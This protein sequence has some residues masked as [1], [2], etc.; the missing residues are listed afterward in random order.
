MGDRNA[1][2]RGQYAAESWGKLAI[3]AGFD[4]VNTESTARDAFRF[5]AKEIDRLKDAE[6]REWIGTMSRMELHEEFQKTQQAAA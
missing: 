4:P 6:N 3:L 5:C 1:R 2:L